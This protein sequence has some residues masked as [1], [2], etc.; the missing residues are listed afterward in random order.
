VCVGR[1][2]GILSLED[3][4]SAEGVDK[5]GSSCGR[6]RQLLSNVAADRLQ[7]TS[8][9]STTDHQA[10]LD[11]FLDIL[12]SADLDLE[13]ANVSYLDDNSFDKEG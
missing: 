12:L 3:L 4:L 2:I 7:L 9:R 11:T 10:K 8:T 6:I 1:V 5:G 13:E